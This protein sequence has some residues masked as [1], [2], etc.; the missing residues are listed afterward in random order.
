MDDSKLNTSPR[1]TMN[2]RQ[3]KWLVTHPKSMM[4]YQATRR[5]PRLVTPQSPLIDLLE[6]I[7]PRDRLRI[8][9]ARLHSDLGYQSG[10]VFPTLEA[11]YQWIKP[12]NEMVGGEPF[13]AESFRLKGFR[14]ALTLDDLKPHCS[15]WLTR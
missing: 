3:A 8:R 1:K 9:G 12:A 5:L 13:P 6:K 2:S 14:R 10:A 7:P 11:L 15:A 4:Q